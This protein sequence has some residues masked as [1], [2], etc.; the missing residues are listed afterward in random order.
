MPSEEQLQAELQQAMKARDTEKLMV[1]RGVMTAIKNLK[2]ERMVS[3]LSEADIVQLIRKEANK[4]AEAAQFAR[5]ANRLDLAEQNERE[6]AI[7]ESYL[8]QP[9]D[10]QQLEAAIREIAGEVGG[11]QIGPIMQKLRERYAGRFDG[12][13]AS[14]LIRKLAQQ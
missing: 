13:L 7:L 6:K 11:F 1:L 5:Q 9:L 3:S 8:P 12:K 4:R 2:V 14:E 10:P